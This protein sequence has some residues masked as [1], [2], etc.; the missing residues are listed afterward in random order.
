M[1]LTDLLRATTEYLTLSEEK[2]Q[3][4]KACADCAALSPCCPLRCAAQESRSGCV[5]RDF[6]WCG[7]MFITHPQNETQ[8]LKDAWERARTQRKRVHDSVAAANAQIAGRIGPGPND[9]E[10][11]RLRILMA[12]ECEAAHKYI[13]H[14]ERSLRG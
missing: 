9:S 8:H 1:R 7:G 13:T 6:R 14:L 12:I 3:T 10:L 11:T 4:C 5:Q 2:P